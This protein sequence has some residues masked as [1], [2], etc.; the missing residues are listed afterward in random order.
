MLVQLQIFAVLAF[1]ICA[2][3]VSAFRASALVPRFANAL[4]PRSTSLRA[5]VE[6][7]EDADASPARRE[8]VLSALKNIIDPNAG[9]DIIEAGMV[10]NVQVIEQDVLVNLL[11]DKSSASFAD[12]VKKLCILELSMLEWVSDIRIELVNKDAP[13]PPTGPPPGSGL[14]KIKHVVAVSS[15]KGGV[16]KSTVAVNLA[17]TL[18]K[19]GLKVGI[20][21]ADIYGPSLP[22]MTRPKLGEKIYQDNKLKP[23]QYEG[24]QLLSLGF[25]SGGAAIMRGPMVNQI[26][27]QFVL[28][29]DW[30]ELDYLIIDMPPGTG[31]IQLTLA[32]IMNISAAVIVTTPQKLSFVD[33]VKGIDMFDTVGVPSVAVVENMAEYST[34]SFSGTRIFGN[35]H[36]RKLKEM[37]G[38]ENIVSLPLLEELSISGDSGVPFVL[39]HPDSLLAEQM[40][41]LASGVIKEVE[42]LATVGAGPLLTFDEPSLMMD[43]GGDQMSA[44]D[45]RCDCRCAVCVEEM[46]GVALLNKASVN[47]QVKPVAMAPIGRYAMSVDWSDGHKALYPFR[48]IAKLAAA[49]TQTQTESVAAVA[50]EAAVAV[51]APA[52]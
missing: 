28:M 34:Y 11:I 43:Y 22:T 20:L 15:C 3:P 1:A 48:Q 24:V 6:L 36:I 45:L 10:G 46:T 19:S 42:R 31:D 41:L 23:L 47:P 29:S 38:M 37:W 32:Q 25:I 50:G 16:G 7:V 40:S 8:E 12:E 49:Q 30:G 13:A 9:S 21:D 26:L 4:V 39:T 44:F 14:K 27:N 17:Y 18:S 2:R 35:G 5:V 51:D 52:S 33:V